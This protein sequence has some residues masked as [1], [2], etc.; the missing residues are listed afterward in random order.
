MRAELDRQLDEML[1]YGIVEEILR[2]Y[3]SPV[4]MVKKKNNEYRLCG[5]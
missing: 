5:L 4:V 3:C 2:N 1:K